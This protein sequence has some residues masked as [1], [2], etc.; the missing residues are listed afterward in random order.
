[1]IV[2]CPVCSTRYLVD[3]RALGTAGRLVRCASCSHTWQ[4]APPPDAPRRVDLVAPQPELATPA[5]GRVQLPALPPTPR[6]SAALLAP[7][8]ALFVLIGAAVTGLWLARDEVVGYWP[9][10]AQYYAMVGAPMP[11]PAQGG[12]L[13]FDK[14]T[15]R[16][17]TENG[18]LTLVIEGEVVNLSR[19][20]RDVPKLRVVLQDSGKHELQSWSFAVTDQ[21]LLAGG[22]L[23]FRTSIAQPNAEA[24][25]FVVTFDSGS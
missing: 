25:G 6:R 22:S 5:R 19:V 20:A 16:Y 2:T 14:V 11:P 8:L 4:Q 24:T 10:A 7:L 3:P 18:L 23:S 15:K 12:G 13:G 21:P 17:D 1:M 9:G